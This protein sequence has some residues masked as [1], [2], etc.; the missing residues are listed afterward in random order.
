MCGMGLEVADHDVAAGLGLLALWSIPCKSCRPGRHPR[1][2]LYRPVGVNSRS[3]GRP[4]AGRGREVAPFVP[5]VHLRVAS[6]LGCHFVTA[7]A[8]PAVLAL[9]RRGV[10]DISSISLM[11]MKRAMIP[12]SPYIPVF[13]RTA[14]SPRSRDSALPFNENR[15][16]RRN[17]YRV[18]M[19]AED[20]GRLR[21]PKAHM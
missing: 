16:P 6:S 21:R 8:A 13:R 19:S 4:T 14:L 1:E 17:Y 11:P 15:D 5:S 20:H 2:I 9:M 7:R 12:P 10:V 18:E 3:A